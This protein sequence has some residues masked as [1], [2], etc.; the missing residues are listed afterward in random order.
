M[1]Q[2][3]KL[4]AQLDRLYFSPTR[5]MFELFDLQADPSEFHNLAGTPDAAAV[6]K[7]LKAAL[8]EWMILQRDFVP[9]PAAPEAKA[10]KKPGAKPAGKRNRG[11]KPAA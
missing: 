11:A 5:P 4:D 3:G 2:D 6:E 7:E 10:P 9:L 1:H 8:Q